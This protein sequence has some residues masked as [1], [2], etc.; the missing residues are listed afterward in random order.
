MILLVVLLTVAVI[1]VGFYCA[2]KMKPIMPLWLRLKVLTPMFLAMF[3]IWYIADRDID[4]CPAFPIVV[5]LLVALLISYTVVANALGDNDK[6]LFRR[7]SG[8]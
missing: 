6:R 8:V 5:S 4:A 7:F 3:S 1:A 2:F